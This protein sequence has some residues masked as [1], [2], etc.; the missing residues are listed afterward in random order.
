M[1]HR[2]NMFINTLTS[3]SPPWRIMIKTIDYCCHLLDKLIINPMQPFIKTHSNI[4]FCI[5]LLLN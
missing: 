2:N 5:Y 4:T 1:S 3:C